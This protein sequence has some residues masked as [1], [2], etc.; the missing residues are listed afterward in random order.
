MKAPLADAFPLF[1]CLVRVL[2]SPIE[3][4]AGAA[5]SVAMTRV[6]A[7]NTAINPRVVWFIPLNIINLII[8]YLY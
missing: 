4:N 7:A 8:V 5:A 2:P 1:F 6:A 3:A